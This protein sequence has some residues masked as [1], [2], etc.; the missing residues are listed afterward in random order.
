MLA[1]SI[2]PGG[3]RK[4]RG[5]FEG[6]AE[7]GLLDDQQFERLLEES[8]AALAPF[9]QADGS[10]VFDMPALILRATAI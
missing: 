9:R 6:A 2:A 5:F 3:W 4:S 8:E 1:L 7:G 10:V